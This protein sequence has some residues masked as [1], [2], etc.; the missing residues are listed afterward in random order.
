MMDQAS[1]DRL[2][3]RA[4]AANKERDALLAQQTTASGGRKTLIIAAVTVVLV[5]V[6]GYA[7]NSA[8]QPGYWD[9]FAKCLSA[10]G[11]VMYGASFCQYSKE[12]RAMFG[13]SFKFIDYKDYAEGK[14]VVRTPTWDING[15]RYENVQSFERLAALTGCSLS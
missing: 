12:Q 7:L 10:K 15:K 3:Q 5:A 6:A 4:E 11:A 2:R 1:H 8:L 9:S 13:K 14:N